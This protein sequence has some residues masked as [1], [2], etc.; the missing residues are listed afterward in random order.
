MVSSRKVLLV[1]GWLLAVTQ[2][3]EYDDDEADFDDYDMEDALTADQLRK[4]HAKFDT[5]GNGKVSFQEVMSHAQDM[6][7]AIAKMD[8]RAILEE[9]DT[10][11]DGMLSLE[12]HITDVSNHLDGGDEEELKEL[13]GR[14]E[15]ERAKF[16]AAD[17]N[18]DGQL[19]LREL[20]GLFFPEIHE[21]VLGVTVGET[22]RQK[23][24]DKDGRLSAKEFWEVDEA[25]GEGS[26]LTEEEVT[27]FA[28]LD[29]DR[30][31]H[32]DLEELRAWESGRF[33]TKEA[34]KRLFELADKDGDMHIT[35]D[36]LS[37]AR[38]LVANSDAQYH[39]MEWAE[40]HEL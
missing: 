31:G 24:V 3:D 7:H 1:L 2:A 32:L 28:A 17:T 8:I 5:D 10:N 34:M 27:D 30:D 14:K 25:E 19:D 16:R 26:E 39:L 12:E 36:E 35:A 37:E 11:K 4:M 13:E 21:G 38:E 22:M 29:L 23:D 20:P 33:H 18:G 15:V 40:H 6:A 9:I